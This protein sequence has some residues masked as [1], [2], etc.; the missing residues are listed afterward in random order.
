MEATEKS[1]YGLRSAPRR[2]RDQ[3]ENILTKCG[4]TPNMVDTCLWTHTTKRVALAIH[5][6]DLLLAETR[7]TVTEILTEPSRDLEIKSSEV[8]TLPGTNKESTDSSLE[9]LYGWT[10]LTYLVRLGK[11]H[12]AL[13]MRA[14][15]TRETSNQSCGTSVEP[16]ES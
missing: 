14:T 12:Q 16:L 7:Q 15:Q 1:L 3:L 10:E 9:N 11:P 8:A 4:F 6:D 5:V 13:D 2:W